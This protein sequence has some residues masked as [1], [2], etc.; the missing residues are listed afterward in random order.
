MN[1]EAVKPISMPVVRPVPLQTRG[2]SWWRQTLAWLWDA[3][4]W[5][6]IE[7]YVY[8]PAGLPALVIP[9]GFLTDFASS[10]RLFWGIG[11]DPAGILLI[12]SLFHDW[13]YRH[14]FYLTPEGQRVKQ[15]AGKSFHDTLLRQISA[16]VN[17]MAAPGW[18]ALLALDVCGWPAWWAACKRRTGEVDLQ[19]EYKK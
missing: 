16:E 2:Q 14:D 5:E 6:L 15:G 8:Q 9:K 7:D 13:G 11:M 1:K 4:V 19:G 3:R 18:L 10:P 12:P 17:E